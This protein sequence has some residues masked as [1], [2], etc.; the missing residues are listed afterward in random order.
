MKALVVYSSQTGNTRK[1]AEALYSAMDCEKAIRPVEEAPDPSGFD[2]VAVGFWLKAGMPDAKSAA[3]LERLGEVDLFLFATHGAAADS[4]HAKA[5]IAAAR[6]LASKARLRG[7]F[8]C[9][10][11]VAPHVLEKASKKEQPP[12]WLKDAPSASRHPDERDVHG[13]LEAFRKSA[14]EAVKPR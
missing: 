2:F 4:E 7:T 1:L 12:V 13:L 5:G 14:L 8:N 3:Y 10:G 11:I 6:E 9:Q